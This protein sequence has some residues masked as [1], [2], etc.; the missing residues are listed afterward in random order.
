MENC[1]VTKLK[2]VV[3]NDNLVRIG[4]YKMH[5]N[6]SSAKQSVKFLG[7]GGTITILGNNNY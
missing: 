4:E 1:L 3:N 7:S 6:L 2:S 5:I